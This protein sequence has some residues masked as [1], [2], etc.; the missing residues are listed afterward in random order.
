QVVLGGL[1]VPVTTNPLLAPLMWFIPARWGFD[2]VVRTERA[3]V[4]ELPGWSIPLPDAPTSLPDFIY[5][6]KFHCALAQ[7]QSS[8][9][10]GA[11]G[12]GSGEWATHLPWLVLTS[13]TA[14]LLA[15]VTLIL[16]QRH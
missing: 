10:P 9:L 4:D 8:D 13:M 12:F 14:L 3:L 6:E 11:W 1:M 16:R 7:L 2:G 15:L 5:Q